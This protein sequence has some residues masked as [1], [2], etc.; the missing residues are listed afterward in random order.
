MG[1]RAHLPSSSRA[2]NRGV[3]GCV[4][5][6]TQARSVLAK[7]PDSLYIAVTVRDASG[8]QGRRNTY[9]IDCCAGENTN[10][11]DRSGGNGIEHVP[12]PY[13]SRLLDDGVQPQQ[14]QG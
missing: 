2:H 9:A 5:V 8:P 14:E 13:A 4:T 10:W 1:L 3:G 7:G 12:P 6:G 11:V